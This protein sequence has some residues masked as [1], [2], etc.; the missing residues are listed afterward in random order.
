V[1]KIELSINV[2]Y[3]PEWSIWEG[4]RELIQN[5]KD[6]ETE[7]GHQLTIT[8]QGKMLRIENEGA[9]LTKEALLFGTTSKAERTDTIG[10][11]GEGLKL[12]VLALVRAG[13]Q[14]KIRS[15]G[16]V[17]TPSIQ[18]SER[19]KADVLV[20]DIKGGNEPKRR[21]R[22]EVECSAAEWLEL[23]ERFLFVRPPVKGGAID[24]N[25]GTLLTDPSFVGK[26]FVKGIFVQFDARLNYGYDFRNATVDRDRKMVASWDLQYEAAAIW[27]DAV[28][29]NPELMDKF[30]ALASDNK[31][32]V[33]QLE[34]MA[35][36][37]DKDV[38]VAVS[39]KFKAQHGT[40]AI[41]VATLAES[42]DVEH[43]GARGIVVSK[44]LQSLLAQT[45]GEADAVK[46][47]LQHEVVRTLSWADISDVQRETL[48]GAIDLIAKVRPD[49]TI[50]AVDVVEYRSDSLLGQFTPAT[51]RVSVAAR[52]LDDRDELLA[53]LVHEFAHRFGND[54]DVGHVRAIEDLWRDIVKHLRGAAL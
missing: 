42:R 12:G 8:Q 29:A 50:D 38:L 2:N 51:S 1:S 28:A 35:S 32:D 11:F 7:N 4:A 24:T 45:F 30:F 46:R 17:W 52:L 16:E 23:R 44:P 40:R 36:Y 54:G 5:G 19:Y 13:R 20:F 25:R 48:T 3:L 37:V 21:V 10:R 26:V 33:Q 9:E 41:P 43:L 15:G 6:E 49:C 53:T 18:R 39:D 31:L 47:Q 27:R 22:V 34:N 14:V